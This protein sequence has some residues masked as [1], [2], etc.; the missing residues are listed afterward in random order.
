MTPPAWPFR[1][2]LVTALMV[3]VGTPPAF[4]LC[5]FPALERYEVGTARAERVARPTVVA[6]AVAA[7]G[8]ALGLA[9]FHAGGPRSG[10]VDRP[11]ARW[12][13][14]ALSAGGFAAAGSTW[15]RRRRPGAV[16]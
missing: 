11:P 6:A 12:A 3:L 10:E 5:V 13:W 8:A 7:L 14:L 1:A 4:G 16:G 15:L 9:A 2:V